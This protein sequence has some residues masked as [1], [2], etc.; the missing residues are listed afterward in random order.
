MPALAPIALRYLA[1]LVGLRILYIGL[2]AI[3][4]LP[5]T[6]A[7]IVILASAPAVEIAIYALR[8][9]TAPIPFKGWATIWAL[10]MAIYLVIH[11]MIPAFILPPFRALLADASVLGSLLI[12]TASTGAMLALFLWLGTRAGGNRRT[13]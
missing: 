9:A 8:K 6:Q 12:V 3:T 11:V 13:G 5:N 10:L 2:T 7:T 4:G 1:W